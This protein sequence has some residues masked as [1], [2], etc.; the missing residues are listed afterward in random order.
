MVGASRPICI[1]AGWDDAPHLS[2][3]DKKKL[4][5]AIPA[6][7]REARTKG[8]PQLGAGAIYPF[9]EDEVVCEPFEIPVHFRRCYALDVGWNRT[10]AL[11][12]AH[13]Q[14]TDV[15]Y[16]YAEHYRGQ[17]EP[18]VHA[19]AINRRGDWIPGVID[20]AARGRSQKDGERLIDIYGGPGLGLKLSIAD[21]A[22]EAG[23][24]DVYDRFSTGRL[25]IFSTLRNTIGELRIYR[26]DEKGK[27][28]K[29]RDHLMDCLRYG[30]RSGLALG[31]YP[32]RDQWHKIRPGR[33]AHEHDYDASPWG[34]G[35]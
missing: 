16:A 17:A 33:T 5:S 35:R 31:A 32:P 25:K 8:I 23:I 26:R 34:R 1:Q 14:D 3:A 28:V 2:E 21:N 11:W 19:S 24:L 30:V 20:P 6:Y 29:E 9:G 18:S 27:I 10:A 22:V 13:D 15:V 7:Q 12:L 4:Y